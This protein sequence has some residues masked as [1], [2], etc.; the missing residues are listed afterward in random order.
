MA[1]TVISSTV[2][3]ASG[4]HVFA[5]SYDALV[6]TQGGA[7]I[8]TDEKAV[9][10][11]PG[12]FAN[13]LLVDGSLISGSVVNE[14]VLLPSFS[15]M[16]VG[17]T[18]VVRGIGNFSFATVI[19]GADV[20]AGSGDGTGLSLV[21]RGE[22]SAAV[23]TAVAMRGLVANLH[24]TGD[25]IGG[26]FGVVLTDRFGHVVNDGMIAA[27]FGSA[28]N[29]EGDSTVINGGAIQGPSAAFGGAAVQM[30]GTASLLRNS[31][32]I[33]GARAIDAVVTASDADGHRIVNTGLI[34]GE[35]SLVSTEGAAHSLVNRGTIA[36]AILFGNGDDE[37][38]GR[39]GVVTGAVFGGEGNDTYRVSDPTILLIEAPDRASETGIVSGGIDR[40]EASVDWT[41]GEHFEVLEL[42]GKAVTGVGN[43]LANTI[44]GN[45][46]NNVLSGLDGF[47]TIDGG[48]GRDTLDGGSGND[49]LFGGEGDDALFGR[50]GN[51]RLE[52]GEGDD[53][54]RGGANNDQLFGGD[55]EDVLYGG[56]GRDILTGGADADR[57]VFAATVE[58]P[59]GVNR[60]I[61][62]D[63]QKGL[64]LIDL[65]RIDAR[66]NNTTA[67]DA[68]TFIGTGAFTGTAGQLRYQIV[69]G[70]TVI[71]FDTDGNGVADG[72]IQLTGAIAL[73]AGDFVL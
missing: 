68:F 53:T 45:E 40:V 55:G 59:A 69:G 70:N 44:T 26:Q 47:D 52:G 18:G 16:D 25:I 38:D 42:V 72:E 60:D 15:R 2:V 1:T 5:Q 46:G 3:S 11:A 58:T 6:V 50:L 4:T 32:E 21:N 67:D 8:V 9:T 24:N 23:T 10:F 48:H 13:Y 29:V 36:G 30:N 62:A 64:D 22:I 12:V 71:G 63:F 41:L 56:M 49:R 57:F 51:D 28:L 66:V 20:I 43:A 33:R 73:S 17:A 65:S 27:T 37:F 39:G 31:G 7:L 14:T 54:L 61:I 34:A 19:M 35:I